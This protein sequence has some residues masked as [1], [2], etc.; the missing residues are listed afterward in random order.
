MAKD[1]KV[2]TQRHVITSQKIRVV[3]NCLVFMKKPELVYCTTLNTII[4]V[5]ITYS[6]LWQVHSL[7]QKVFFREWDLQLFFQFLAHSRFLK[8]IQY[9]FTFSFS[10]SPPFYSFFYI[11][12][13]NMFW[14]RFV[15]RTFVLLYIGSSFSPWLC[16]MLLH[17]SHDWS[18]GVSPS[19]SS[20]TL[21][22][23]Q[24]TSDL[25]YTIYNKRK[26]S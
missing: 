5:I 26:W 14:Q 11:S 9:L 23:V 2:L 20:T 4:I 16:L 25:L 8:I 10:S 12:F 7:F 24:G 15:S 13:S 22:N 21:L 3:T 19:F 1:R 18:N 6:L 17:S